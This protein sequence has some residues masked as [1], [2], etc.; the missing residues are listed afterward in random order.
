MNDASSRT[1]SVFHSSKTWVFLAAVSCF[2]GALI[3]GLSA[4]ISAAIPA[5]LFWWLLIERPAKPTFPRGALF[6]VLTVILAHFLH[7]TVAGL[8]HLPLIGTGMPE[9]G[10]PTLSQQTT[11]VEFG[12]TFGIIATFP[13]GIVLGLILVAIRRRFSTFPKGPDSSRKNNYHK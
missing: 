6:G 10:L 1:H 3:Y 12:L 7:L 8:L 4:A 2:L 5:P 9:T 11:W 13:I